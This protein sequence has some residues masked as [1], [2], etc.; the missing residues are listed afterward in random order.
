MLIFVNTGLLHVGAKVTFNA[1]CFLIAVI[2][3]DSWFVDFC[4]NLLRI[5]FPTLRWKMLDIFFVE[6]SVLTKYRCTS[7]ELLM[8]L[9][10]N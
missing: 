1:S 5:L 7:F 4:L 10:K 8:F 9:Y 6:T 2:I 3:G